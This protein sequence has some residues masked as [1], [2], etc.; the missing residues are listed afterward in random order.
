MYNP[1]VSVVIPAYNASN[2]LSEAIDSA[3]AQTYENIEIIVVNDGSTDNGA[4]ERVALSYGDKVRY[5][6]K[7]N[8]G[9]A[10]ALN[11]GIHVMQGEWFSWLSHDDLYLPGKIEKLLALLDEYHCDPGETVLGCNDRILASHKQIPSLFKNSSGMIS[12]IQAFK[13]NLNVKTMNGC[14]LLIPK[15]VLD[16]VGEFR[17]DYKHL[18]DRE[19]WMRIA[20][21]GFEYSYTDEPLV[22]SRA[23]NQQITVQAQ[24]QLYNEE[25]K[26]INEYVEIIRRTPEKADYLRELCYFSYKRRH[27]EQGKE[28]LNILQHQGSLNARTIA[29]AAKYCLKGCLRRIVGKVYKRFIRKG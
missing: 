14:G 10:S 16:T 19:M 24:N 9:C 26:L 18:L 27:Y 20:L 15:R 7:E 2:Y 12:P 6:G 29:I 3:L 8:G 13:E 22:L 1:L 4:T 17:T 11:Y 21:R 5:F 23:H 28:I 25:S